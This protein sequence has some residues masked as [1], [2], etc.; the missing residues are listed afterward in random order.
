VLAG[1]ALYLSHVLAFVYFFACS[2]LIVAIDARRSPERRRALAWP[3][4]IFTGLILVYVLRDDPLEGTFTY[5]SGLFEYK[6]SVHTRLERLL[7]YPWSS[8]WSQAH[9]L[10]ASV[11]VLVAPWLMGLR[12]SRDHARYAPLVTSLVFWFALPH[13][14]LSTYLVYERFAILL[15][16]A[17]ALIF[18]APGLAL[19]GARARIKAL[20]GAVFLS[21]IAILTARPI[22]DRAFFASETEM[23][24]MLLDDLPERGRALSLVYARS[25]D[26]TQNPNVYL[27]FPQWYAAEKHGLVDFS[28][29]WFHPQ[30]VRFRRRHLPE[31]APSFEWV[32][33]HFVGLERCDRYDVLIV[34]A[35]APLPEDALASSSCSHRLASR[36]GPWFAYRLPERRRDE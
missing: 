30:P 21:I 15:F 14:M 2:A 3:H 32:P 17:Y 28:F 27:H 22:A 9:L 6:D 31:I 13:Y 7:H 4:A 18:D 20:G 16:P 8:T 34:R 36:Q 11:F 1:V 19:T 5:G 29:A 26:M 24:R 35:P 23:F 10:F 12:P 33:W 25:S